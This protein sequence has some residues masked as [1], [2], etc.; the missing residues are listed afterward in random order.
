MEKRPKTHF[1]TSQ[2]VQVAQQGVH[3][4]PW[5]HDAEHG[6]RPSWKFSAASIR[7]QRSITPAW[8]GSVERMHG[9]EIV[10]TEYD[11]SRAAGS[12]TLEEP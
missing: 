9:F 6:H 5:P 10:H 12:P 2:C 11:L 4:S 1:F 7:D 3:R 8:N